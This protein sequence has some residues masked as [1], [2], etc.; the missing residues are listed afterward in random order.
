MILPV[1]NRNLSPTN[2]IKLKVYCKIKNDCDLVFGRY[3]T[4]SINDPDFD[5]ERCAEVI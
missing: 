4:N 2:V 5:Q 1:H 3:L